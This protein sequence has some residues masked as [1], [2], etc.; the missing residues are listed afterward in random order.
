MPLAEDADAIC[1][2]AGFILKVHFSLVCSAL[3]LALFPSVFWLARPKGG[4][5]KE[6][7][8]LIIYISV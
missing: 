4:E 6:S 2:S 1:L 3:G 7:H 5:K 8:E